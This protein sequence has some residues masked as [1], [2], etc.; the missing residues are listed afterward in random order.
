MYELAYVSCGCSFG[1]AL[2]WLYFLKTRLIRTRRE[3]YADRKA[4]GLW[5]PDD[6]DSPDPS[7]Y[8]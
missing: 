8:K 5:A 7:D 4:R 2:A 6:W 3:W 1:F